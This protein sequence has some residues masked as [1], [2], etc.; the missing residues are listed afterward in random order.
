MIFAFCILIS[1][2]QLFLY[3]LN[4]YFKWKYGIFLTVF[5]L[6][7]GYI[8]VFPEWFYPKYEEGD[9]K[10]GLPILGAILGTWIFGFTSLIGTHV[11]Y[12]VNLKKSWKK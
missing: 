1:L 2:I 5:V 3:Y 6:I 10:C 12:R 11:F 7:V 9:M 8:F 4:H